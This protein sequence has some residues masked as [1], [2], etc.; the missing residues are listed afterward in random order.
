MLDLANAKLY[1]KKR[2]VPEWF[3]LFILF[4]PFFFGFLFS[5]LGLPDFLK[6]LIDFALLFLGVVVI[7]QRKSIV[8]KSLIPAGIFI[9]IFLGYTLVNYAFNFQSVF[10][11]IWGLRNN[12]R[13]YGAFL[14]FAL[15][16][17]EDEVEDCFKIF[18]AFYWFNFFVCL[19]QYFL[20]G[21]KQDYLGGIFGVERGC[22]GYINIFL[23]VIIVRTIIN[24]LN[25]KESTASFLLKVGSAL[26]LSALAELKFFFIEF[27][28]LVCVASLITKFSWR[29][30]VIIIAS[31]V[32]VI[33]GVTLLIN[34]FPDFA[35][36]FTI[37]VIFNS[38]ASQGGYTNSEDI[39][40][41]TAIPIISNLFLTKPYQRW[42][43]LGLGNCDLSSISIFNTPFYDKYGDFNY[44][45]FSYSFLYLEVGYIGMILFFGFFIFCFIYARSY[46]M[47]GMANKEYCQM[48]MAMAV[49]CCLIAIYG[50]SLRSDGAYMAYFMLSL[51]FISSVSYKQKNTLQG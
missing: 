24:Y 43:G 33:L 26:I 18:D 8:A 47:K 31:F 40:R 29:K 45:W 39:N 51:P 32:G 3:V 6:F 11:Y 37:E 5:F 36:F 44:D 25:R 13:F 34:L 38:A 49:L 17:T 23:C 30:F 46:Y 12:F 14:L 27:I 28:V 20:L 9:L 21:F 16:F 19:V 4:F 22:N 48:T 35:D 1:I 15:I 10:Y 2:R 50:G 7:I 42:F 41:L